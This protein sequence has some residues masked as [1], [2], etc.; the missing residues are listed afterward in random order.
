MTCG[1]SE[2]RYGN[3]LR[4]AHVE[5]A[6][7]PGAGAVQ[8]VEGLGTYLEL[9]KITVSQIQTNVFREANGKPRL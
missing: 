1:G 3:N 8:P 9:V 2:D 4:T 7:L 5:V 6:C